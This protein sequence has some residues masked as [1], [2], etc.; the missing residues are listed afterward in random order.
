VLAN[1][2]YIDEGELVLAPEMVGHE[3]RL[4]FSGGDDGLGVIRR[5]IEELSAVPWVALEV[6]DRQGATVCGLLTRAGFDE[7]RVHRDFTGVERVVEGGRAH[8]PRRSDVA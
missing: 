4:A 2:P 8:A 3:P 5:L 6:G 1:P 7:V